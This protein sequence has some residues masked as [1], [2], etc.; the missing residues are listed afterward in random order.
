[1]TVETI[2]AASTRQ[3]AIGLVVTTYNRPWYAWRTLRCLRRSLQGSDVAVAVVDD[4]SSSAATLRVVRS[5]ASG[6]LPVA[7]LLK[8]QRQG[9]DVHNSLKLGW[10]YLHR[11]H[12]CRYLVNIDSDV[13]SKPGWLETLKA[14]F[15]RER[16]RR[17]PLLLTGFNTPN[18]PVLETH[19]DYCIKK[20]FGG[21]NTFFDRAL[22]EETVRPNLVFN[23][24]ENWGWD[25]Y[26]VKALREASYPMLCSRPSVVQHIG[27]LGQ[28]SRWRHYDKAVDY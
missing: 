17:G 23:K 15:E 5:F 18:H 1:M 13:L 26:V 21:I 9:F 16:R 25:W 11:Q 6:P 24:E 22:Y 12:G 28:W 10:D 27:R 2:P 14:L 7:T 19:E 3:Y 20:S 8:K 4:A